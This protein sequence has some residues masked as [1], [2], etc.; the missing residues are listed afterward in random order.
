MI[1]NQVIKRYKLILVLLFGSV[2][3]FGQKH[4][5]FFPIN[6]NDG[7]SG[8]QVRC[9]GQLPDRR[10]VILTKGLVNLYDGT[11]FK[12]LHFNEGKTYPLSLYNGFHRMYVDDAHR[13]WIKNKHRLM[14]FD[15]EKEI[16]VPNIDSV[17]KK[18]GI[19]EELADLFMDSNH[20][21]WYLTHN[22]SLL[23]HG[24]KTNKS[25][26][27]LT[28]VTRAGQSKEQ[29]YDIAVVNNQL[30]LFYKSGLM[31][32]YDLKSRELLYEQNA[33]AANGSSDYQYT[34]MVVPYN[35][36]LYQI[37]NGQNG[38]NMLRYNVKNMNWKKIIEPEHRLNTLTLDKSGNCY[39]S[40][41][42]GFW[43][44][45][46]TLSEKKYIPK[47]SL[48]D[49]RVFKTEI[50]TQYND[51]D[52][53]LWIGTLNKGILYFHPNRFLFRNTG[54]SLFQGLSAKNMTANCFAEQGE[55]LFIGTNNG[56]FYRENANKALILFRQIPSN[57]HCNMMLTDRKQKIWLCTENSGV[58]RLND[59]AV[60]HF[61][62]N[63]RCYYI[64]EAP[65]DNF[66]LFTDKGIHI[67][68]EETN[69]FYALS[70]TDQFNL[71]SIKQVIDFGPGFLICISNSS[72]FIF[73]LLKKEIDTLK[74]D[75]EEIGLALQLSSHHYNTV[76][77][78]SRGLIWIGTQDGLNV[79]DR[80]TGFKKCFHTED[81][82]VNN[83]VQS[84]IEDNHNQIW[85]STSSGLSAID[86]QN[87]NN[88]FS[89]S[90]TNYNQY[91]GVIGSES[92]PRSVFK[93]TDG[94]LF[95]GGI[96]GFNELD[97]QLLN[98]NSSLVRKP[99]L[100]NLHVSGIEIKQGLEYHGQTILNSSIATTNE[101][102]L[103]HH[104]NFI[105][106][107]FSAMNYI[108][109]FRTFYRYQLEGFEDSWQIIASTNGIGHANYTNLPPGT[110][111]LKIQ[112]SNNK[113]TWG[114]DYTRFIIRIQPPIWKTPAFFVL[115]TVIF[116][117]IL[118]FTISYFI[119]R[120]KLKRKREQKE[121]LDQMKFS[122]FTNVSH[123]LRT[124]LTLIIT[125]L[126]SI[127]SKTKDAQ[128]KKQLG[129]VK[130]NADELLKLVN[131]L[132]DF[133]K[134][135][136]QGEHLQLSY[137]NL[138]GLI[139]SICLSFEEMALSK[140]I[141]FSWFS[142]DNIN[143][144]IDID[145]LHKIV[146]NLLSNAYKFTPNGGEISVVLTKTTMPNSDNPSLKIEVKD[147]GCGIPESELAHIFDRFYQSKR[148]GTDEKGS[149]IGLHMVKE[150]IRL[151][152]GEIE[153]ESEIHE[154]SLFS[155]HIPSYLKPENQYEKA[156]DSI[157]S[158]TRTKLLIAEDNN[159]LRHFLKEELS[160]HYSV[161][162]AKNGAVALS[163]VHEHHPDLVISDYSMPEMT[164]YDLCKQIKKHIQISHIP[165]IMLTAH[166]S[167]KDQIQS[168]KV[169]ADAYISKPFNMDILLLR[170]QK[171]IENQQQRKDLFKKA[172][173]IQP[174]K[175]TSTD[176]DEE[177]IKKALECVEK[178]MENPS[179]SIDQFSK[180]M[181]MDRTGLYRKLKAVVGQ[182]PST[183]MRSV[184]LKRSAQ[185][186][187]NGL[188]VNEVADRVGFGSVSYFSKSFH[189]E[190]GLKPS[191]YTQQ[192]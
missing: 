45:N 32:C 154:G 46:Q 59:L 174:E 90:L 105:N 131:Q 84:V 50:S 189:E 123:E 128:L 172:I 25:I 158:K 98:N 49:G 47:L 76:F 146:N 176:I 95:W 22:N 15:I 171:L 149:G 91:D 21:F 29:L 142:D 67:F 120:N 124:P 155:V 27:F 104:Q 175:V 94:R 36:Y 77:N 81:G 6:S 182:S 157:D 127:L 133:R 96:N 173:L 153:V 168:F 99:I 177:L 114:D 39:V 71:N 100:S 169:G 117:L 10:M 58:Y 44:I 13:L 70:N 52:G 159:E 185:L 113:E 180:D 167:D 97:T 35:H 51:M 92:Q 147:S 53:G 48:E 26:Q 17:L 57:V 181:F 129:N 40:T 87:N 20:D 136:M 116:I 191:Q 43:Y 55:V 145:K 1:A 42:K 23:Y 140:Q 125:P 161:I 28:G 30:F 83:C 64:H 12:Y 188:P 73:D 33:L 106:V 112:A 179:Y 79:W 118:Y 16:F 80:N 63:E 115:Y 119:N 135:E 160:E 93:T 38:G 141:H 2:F 68:S 41:P 178:N 3:L 4:F 56:L 166:T 144:Y 82:L 134:L 54:R 108:N 126:D 192:K 143:A 65:D 122:F 132:L 103:K 165:F 137:C 9:I 37:R 164:G 150:Y 69:L 101:I 31:S 19:F 162:T 156:D 109:P 121:A 107:E 152:Q 187:K 186:L 89:F 66:Y 72:I 60:Q 130:K 34:L 163:M 5:V 8:N 102:E 110:Y 78:D 170:I 61:P 14:L 151:H 88:R 85:V 190:F 183:F 111:Q 86:V 75:N 24:S 18:Q 139:R 7:L 74:F 138:G 62:V 184:R 11:N 148:A